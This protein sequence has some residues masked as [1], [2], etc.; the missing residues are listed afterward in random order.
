MTTITE[1]STTLQQLLGAT[2]N[3]LAK[4]TG[5][6]R[7]QRRVTGAGFAQTLVLG[8]LVEPEATRHQQQQAAVQV[9]MPISAQGLEQRFTPAAAAFM[10]ALLEVGLTQMV[11]SEEGPTLLPQFN[12]VYV[13]DCTRLDLQAGG[14]KLGVRWELQH[15]QLQA[16]LSELKQHDQKS[17]VIAQPLPAGAL[18]LGDLG[19]FKLE[20]FAR[21]AASEVEQAVLTL[22]REG[23]LRG[24]VLDL[25]GNPGGL[26]EAAV[27]ISG[28]FLPQGAVVVPVRLADQATTGRQVRIEAGTSAPAP[29]RTEILDELA[30]AGWHTSAFVPTEVRVSLVASDGATLDA[31]RRCRRP[32]RPVRPAGRRRELAAMT[33]PHAPRRTP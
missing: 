11:A 12:G 26:L 31:R 25:R 28:L 3:A 30:R 10:R 24:L 19:F 6:I 29:E 7:R 9:G 14:V 1:L 8:G 33:P 23:E 2:A 15:G 21:D 32:V 18:H 4:Q 16:S 5:F 13:T 20:R 17:A 22:Q 27:E